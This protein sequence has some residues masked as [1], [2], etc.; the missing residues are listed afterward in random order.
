MDLTNFYSNDIFKECVS[1]LKETSKDNNGKSVEYMTESKVEV[2]DFDKVKEKYIKDKNI[3]GTPK[4]ND[5]LLINSEDDLYF[6]EFKNGSLRKRSDQGELSAKNRDSVLI[7]LDIIKRDLEFTRKNLT[8]ILVYNENKN[9]SYE[10]E[11]DFIQESP[12]R[13]LIGK[14]IASKA[15]KEIIRFGLDIFKN[16]L[17]KDVHTYTK[18]EFNDKNILK[19]TK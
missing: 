4:S 18:D 15:N 16:Y 12:S 14:K 8:Y 10:G 17:F 6:I 2:I 5:V 13:S 19:L 7:F 3:P 1:T 9:P 11:S